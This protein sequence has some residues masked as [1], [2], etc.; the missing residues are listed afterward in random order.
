MIGWLADFFRLW[1]GLIYWNTRKTWFQR[2]RGRSACPCQSPSDS[3]RAFETH[4]EACIPWA[5][6]S[7]FRRVCPLLVDTKDGLRCSADTAQVRPF[8]GRFFAYYGGSA[9]ALY[10]IGA[11]A[12]FAFLRSVGYPV[13]IVHVT[14][15]PLWHKVKE[16]RGWYFLNRAELAFAAGESS[17]GLL[18]LASAY[19]FDPGN[20]RAGITLAK[21][22]QASQ[23][24]RSDLVFQQLLREH[25]SHRS[26][27][28]QDWFRALLPRGDFDKITTL[29]RNELAAGPEHSAVWL[30]ALLFAT[31]QSGKDA[32]LREFLA[33]KWPNAQRWHPVIE[34]ELLVRAGRRAEALA[35]IAEPLP[36]DAPVFTIY[37][38]IDALIDLSEFFAALDQIGKYS[39]RL[40]RDPQ[41]YSTLLLDGYAAAGS[42]QLVPQFEVM[43]RQ[44]L[45]PA[46]TSLLCAHLI[47]HP[48]PQALDI[49][50]RKFVSSPLPLTTENAGAW[51]SLLCAAGAVGDRAKLHEITSRL[52]LAS[53]TPFY[54][55]AAVEAFFRGEI[56]ERRINVFLPILPLP[57]DVTY[58]LYE[59][60]PLPAAL[61]T[62]PP[63][64][65]KRK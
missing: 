23:P 13:S 61:P 12:V 47:R 35:L 65:S 25:P 52:K 64:Q 6:P 39:D 48:N 22:L 2:R 5:K 46:L 27:T 50:W 38:R 43:L 54:A 32:P 30:R 8:W 15:P 44:P 41:A 57:I 37:H 28:A 11:I 4:C 31:K 59:R 26:A 21:H 19:E 3:G 53:T 29:A 51:F 14:L 7:R 49:L 9:I 34:L 42:R 16:T 63:K 40:A 1:W 17:Q 33:Q 60:Y 20:Y 55:L 45:N 62:E 18:Y 10:L 58:A 36:A 24:G 56:N